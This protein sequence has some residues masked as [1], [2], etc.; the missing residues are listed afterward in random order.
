MARGET[1]VKERRELPSFQVFVLAGAGLIA[2]ALLTGIGRERGEAAFPFVWRDVAVVQLLAALPLAGWLAAWMR[3]R[4]ASGATGVMGAVLLG[5]GVVVVAGGAPGGLVE[6]G[7]E[8]AV[9]AGIARAVVGLMVAL[10]AVLV[11]E[12]LIGAGPC[13]A[14]LGRRDV[15]VAALGLAALLVLPGTYVGARCRHDHAQWAGLLEQSRLAEAQALGVGLQT[16]DP[17]AA[18]RGRALRGV[19]AE[20]ERGV[21]EL[22]ARVAAPLPDNTSDA[23]R[24]DRAYDLAM[25]GRTGDALDML[26]GLA[27]P[28]SPQAAGARGLIHETREEWAEAR[29]W[30]A[31]AERAWEALPPSPERE[32]GRLDAARGTGYSARK[33]GL[34]VD[35]ETAYQKVLALAPTAD[36]HFL[37]AQFYEDT[38]Q[39][40]PARAHAL[41]AMALAPGRYAEDGR[42]LIDK[43]VTLHFGCLGVF[44]AERGAS[45]GSLRDGPRD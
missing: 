32:A 28:D 13:G 41:R 8:S 30:Y 18:W 12:V 27:A 4:L 44:N 35:A 7:R 11:A 37:L 38:Q 3:R 2:C 39:A 22:E 17:E 15:L 20:V 10:G 26:D 29:R 9:V 33:S 25:L 16:L 5:T 24:L 31:R 34:L 42:K 14:P 23:T 40:M 6:A 21:R 19:L 43:L 36:S 1:A 45:P